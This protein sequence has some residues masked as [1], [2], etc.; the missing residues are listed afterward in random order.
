MTYIEDIYLK[1]KHTAS[2]P[3]LGAVLQ[4]ARNFWDIR[5]V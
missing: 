4:E 1:F 5:H 2:K 3:P